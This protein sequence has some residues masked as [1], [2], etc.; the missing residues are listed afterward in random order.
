MTLL[1]TAQA[2]QLRRLARKAGIPPEVIEPW[3]PERGKPGRRA[4]D[5]Q[6]ASLELFARIA[7]RDRNMSR[8]RAL[9]WHYD[10]I[11]EKL[12]KLDHNGK[13][14]IIARFGRDADAAV[15]RVSRKLRQGGFEK[16]PTEDLVPREW[17]ELGIDP[18]K[19]TTF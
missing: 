9:L 4:H 2:K 12:R 1:T 18:K 13:S 8:H 15:A 11:F 7:M 14:A 19:F 5:D 16:R 17:L 6:L 10:S 3:L